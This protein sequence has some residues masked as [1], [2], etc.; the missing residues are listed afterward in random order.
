MW[1]FKN[2]QFEIWVANTGNWLPIIHAA[3]DQVTNET[4][5]Y[6]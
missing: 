1:K 3:V 5:T 4:I 6:D 2:Y